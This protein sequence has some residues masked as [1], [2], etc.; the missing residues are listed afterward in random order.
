[1]ADDHRNMDHGRS[2]FAD[3]ADVYEQGRPGYPEPL[4]D[5]IFARLRLGPN[6]RVLDLGAGT[7]KLTRSLADRA[8]EVVAVEPSADMRRVLTDAE[9]RARA[10]DGSA[11]RIPLPD[12][13]VDAVFCGQSFHWF[14]GEAAVAEIGRVLAD[15]GGLALL[16]NVE[17]SRTPEVRDWMNERRYARTPAE[18]RHDTGL[19]K[20]AFADQNAFG[21][22]EEL[23]ASHTQT[24]S[25]DAYLAQIASRSYIASMPDAERRTALAEAA[26]LVG[27]QDIAVHYR[28]EAW[29][30]ARVGASQPR[31]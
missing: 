25:A 11:E 30:T 13:A 9:P 10:L 20:R 22:L 15:G 6:A 2:G 4:L 24:L 16:W 8:A 1:M 17:T 26:R 29:L 27:E 3:S 31:V 7:G 23:E 18:N 28:T 19:W 21:P 14:A 12:A 5:Q